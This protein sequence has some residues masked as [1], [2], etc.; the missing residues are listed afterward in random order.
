MVMSRREFLFVGAA[1]GATATTAVAVPIVKR[2]DTRSDGST[3]ETVSY[4][5]KPIARLSELAVGDTVAF[6]YPA[7][8]DTSLLVRLGRPATGGAGPDSDVVAFSNRCTHMGC[9]IEDVRIDSGVL[10]PCPCH[11]TT[12]DL[13][14]DGQVVLGQATQNLPRVDL[15]LD[16]DDIYAT[17]VTRLIYGRSD[18]LVTG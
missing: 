6:E 13:A 14:R 4:G 18:N 3:R 17:G 7:P 9:P 8:G 5:R 1:A 11:F 2:R 10:G 12:F 16:G 15:E